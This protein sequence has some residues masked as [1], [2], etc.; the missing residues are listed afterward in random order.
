MLP[1]SAGGRHFTETLSVGLMCTHTN[2]IHTH[3]HTHTHTHRETAEGSD[4][5]TN[6]IVYFAKTEIEAFWI[7]TLP[8]SFLD[9]MLRAFH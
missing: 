7:K 9:F 5:T 1:Q 3:T 6:D 8:P 4:N 2:V